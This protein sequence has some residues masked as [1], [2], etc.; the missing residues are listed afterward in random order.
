MALSKKQSEKTKQVK[1]WL[2]ANTPF[3]VMLVKGQ[4]PQVCKNTTTP[5]SQNIGDQTDTNTMLVES[6]ADQQEKTRLPNTRKCDSTAR[7]KP[8][9]PQ[10]SGSRKEKPPSPEKK[11]NTRMTQLETKKTYHMEN[12][13]P[14][15]AQP[16]KKG[17]RPPPKPSKPARTRRP[18][19][20]H[21]K[22]LRSPTAKSKR[23]PSAA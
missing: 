22:S 6:I 2:K 17:R 21:A 19:S 20:A 11:T 16:Q 7:M 13:E 3:P 23:R 8:N 9:P 4:P 18:R 5:N 1:D 14:P 12:A 15:P 10:Q